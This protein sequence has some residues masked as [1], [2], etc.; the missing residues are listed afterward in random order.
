MTDRP[1]S[2]SQGGLSTLEALVAVAILGLALLPIL[3]FQTQISQAYE[4]YELL[5]ARSE[6]ERNALAAL[7]DIN[8]MERPTGQLN[9]GRS[10]SLS[11]TSR[12]LTKER[13]S[14]AY[15]AG[16]GDFIVALYLLKVELSDKDRRTRYRMDLE[17]L[18]WR[19][20]AANAHPTSQF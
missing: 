10:Q 16:D 3:A 6:L 5:N 14:T 19:K 11:W 17:R 12:A 1:L 7:R 13:Q 2:V 9:L 15:P 20:S 18:G 4:R 8:P